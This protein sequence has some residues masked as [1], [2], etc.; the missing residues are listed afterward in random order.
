MASQ[1]IVYN[2]ALGALIQFKG[3]SSNFYSQTSIYCA[4]EGKKK[5][6]V[7]E[8]GMVNIII[9]CYSLINPI[10]CG[11]EDPLKVEVHGKW[12]HSE[13]RFDCSYYTPNFQ[14]PN[15]ITTEKGFPMITFHSF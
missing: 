11:E 12:T 8:M 6:M 7:N 1:S 15:T 4:S 14:N 10:F 9:Y 5:F 3:K 13:W 2:K